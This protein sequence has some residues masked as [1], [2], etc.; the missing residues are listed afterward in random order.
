MV[1]LRRKNH[2]VIG[3]V[4]STISVDVVNNFSRSDAPS[5]GFLRY[6]YVFVHVSIVVRSAVVRLVDALSSA[7]VTRSPLP[8]RACWPCSS[9]YIAFA[10]RLSGWL[11]TAR[12]VGCGLLSSLFRADGMPHHSFRMVPS[13]FCVPSPPV[14]VL[15]PWKKSKRLPLHAP[16]G[17]VGLLRWRRW[18]TA[19]TLAEFLFHVCDLST[20]GVMVL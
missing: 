20:I 14:S 18:I 13:S 5:C 16:E 15:V 12:L 4:V 3:G 11:D 8:A 10:D 19:A 1:G 2:Q 7:T 9:V 6:K 17:L